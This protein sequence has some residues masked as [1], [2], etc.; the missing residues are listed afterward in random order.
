MKL[1]HAAVPSLGPASMPWDL[2][3]TPLRTAVFWGPGVLVLVLSANLGW[4]EHTIGWTAG[5]L[6]LAAMCLWNSRRCRRV[7]CSFTGPF[8]F[9][10]AVVTLLVGFRIISLGRGTWKILGDTIL[11]GAVVLCCGSE[12]IWGRYWLSA[13]PAS[14][15]IASDDPRTKE[16]Q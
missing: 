1:R 6:L 9:A 2:A 11:I 14:N 4:W 5:L 10:M 16:K 3:S 15:C 8:F 13:H 7:H 12:M